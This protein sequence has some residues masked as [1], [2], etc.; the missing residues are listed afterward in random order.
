MLRRLLPA[1][2]PT[3]ALTACL[4][5]TPP[6]QAPDA[7]DENL[8]WFWVNAVALDDA[9]LRE[10]AAK[11]AVAGKADT[12]T[13]A[14]K[15][16]T[17]NRLQ[18]AELAVVGLDKTNDPSTAR[19]MMIVNVFPCTLDKLQRILV[20]QD[21]KSQYAGVYDSYLRTYTSDAAAFT[22][23]TADV[24]T[25]DVDL[26]A[27]MPVDDPYTSSIKGGVR[28]VTAPADSA[29]KGPFLLARTWLPAPATFLRPTSTSYFRQDYQL[30]VFWEQAPGTIFHAYAMWRDIKNGGFNLTIEDNGFMNLVLDNLVKWD[31]TT[32][33]LCG[34]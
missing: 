11:L 13:T 22:A 27:T 14:L 20:A 4:N 15:S 7:L 6:P 29:T 33:A 25:W 18:P 3:L 12:R 31:D 16:A 26:Q 5:A 21:Q 23:G 24:L 17:R 10:G 34:K 28:R 2:L 19:G 8:R 1:L 32:A 30:E 9:A